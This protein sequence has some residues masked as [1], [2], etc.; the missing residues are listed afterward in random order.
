[1][2]EKFQRAVEDLYSRGLSDN[3]ISQILT[4]TGDYGD[5]IEAVRFSVS[6]YN[7]KKREET[8]T[9]PASADSLSGLDLNKASQDTASAS[10]GTGKPKRDT[11]PEV[12]VNV[13]RPTTMGT[14]DPS[15]ARVTLDPRGLDERLGRVV[16]GSARPEVKSAMREAEL[17]D[18]LKA[19]LAKRD[20]DQAQNLTSQFVTDDDKAMELALGVAKQDRG[21]MARGYNMRQYGYSEQAIEYAEEIN[22]LRAERK[23]NQELS[24]AADIREMAKQRGGESEV[25]LPSWATAT[26]GA[27]SSAA[28]ATN[29]AGMATMNTWLTETVEDIYRGVQTGYRGAKATPD[30]LTAFTK[31][32]DNLTNEQI[33]NI[34]A[35]LE[36]G[37]PSDEMLEFNARTLE[38]GNDFFAFFKALAAN[39]NPSGVVMEMIANSMAMLGNEASLKAGA[40]VLAP[41]A[42]R[43]TLQGGAAGASFGG[44]GAVPGAVVGTAKGILQGIP[45]AFSVASTTSATGMMFMQFVQEELDK[46]GKELNR[47]NVRAIMENDNLFNRFRTDALK[48]GATLGAI[49]L[50]TAKMASSVGANLIRRGRIGTGATAQAFG[51]GVGGATAENY[52]Q[53]AIGREAT[54]FELGAEFIAQVAQGAPGTFANIAKAALPK[55]LVEGTYKVNGETVDRDAVLRLVSMTPDAE[56]ESMGI[57]V[58][59][60][61][62]LQDLIDVKKRRNEIRKEMPADMPESQRER[63]VELELEKQMGD[64]KTE[65][66]KK[67]RAEIDEE[68]QSILNPD[69]KKDEET[70][71]EEPSKEETKEEAPAKEEGP[72]EVQ[73]KGEKYTVSKDENGETVVVKAATGRKAKKGSKNYNAAVEAA[74]GQETAD[75]QSEPEVDEFTKE[76]NDY[77]EKHRNS[78][79]VEPGKVVPKGDVSGR[80][81][82]LLN[83]L[84]RVFKTP[85]EIHKTR[86]S[87]AAASKTAYAAMKQGLEVRGF[88][89]DSDGVVHIFDDG[90]KQTRKTIVHEFLHSEN[91]KNRQ[92]ME[93]V[94]NSIVEAAK[95]NETLQEYIDNI[96]NTYE[97]IGFTPDEIMDEIVANFGSDAKSSQFENVAW[98]TIRQAINRMFEQLGLGDVYR[99]KSKN[100][101]VEYLDGVSRATRGLE[102]PGSKTGQ[103]TESQ[104]AAGDKLSVDRP[105]SRYAN[106]KTEYVKRMLNHAVSNKVLTNYVADKYAK[107]ANKFR[108]GYLKYNK[109]SYL[110]ALVGLDAKL[111]KFLKKRFK[112]EGRNYAPGARPDPY[113]GV[114]KLHIGEDIS[115]LARKRQ[116]GELKEMNV[117]IQGRVKC[118]I[119]GGCHKSVQ[120]QR[121]R[122]M[123]QVTAPVITHNMS[124]EQK[125]DLIGKHIAEDI[126]VSQDILP[127][128]FAR[129]ENLY[130]DFRTEFPNEVAAILGDDVV[131][132]HE[133]LLPVLGA[134]TSNGND[135]L[136]N[137]KDTI[138]AIESIA[139]TGAISNT[140][141]DGMTSRQAIRDGMQVLNILLKRPEF[142]GATMQETI[143]NI[144]AWMFQEQTVQEFL[145]ENDQAKDPLY[146]YSEYAK[147]AFPKDTV[148]PRSAMLF[149]PKIGVFMAALNGNENILVHDTWIERFRK[150]IAGEF[151]LGLTR[152]EIKAWKAK[153]KPIRGKGYRFDRDAITDLQ[154]YYAFAYGKKEAGMPLDDTEAM[155][156][157]MGKKLFGKFNE[158]VS[159]PN[160]RIM[161]E[162]VKNA[163]KILSEQ[164]VEL[165][166]AQI[167]QVLFFN[168]HELYSEAGMQNPNT[169]LYSESGKKYRNQ[170]ESVSDQEVREFIEEN[171]KEIRDKLAASKKNPFEGR[172]VV[173][174][175]HA[176]SKSGLYRP[177]TVSFQP[178][179]Y[180]D[181]MKWHNRMTGNGKVPFDEIYS[182]ELTDEFGTTTK[183]AEQPSRPFL[184]ENSDPKHMKSTVLNFRSLGSTQFLTGKAVEKFPTSVLVMKQRMG[185]KLSVDISAS[186]VGDIQGLMAYDAFSAKR[187]ASPT[188]DANRHFVPTDEKDSMDAEESPFFKHRDSA[189]FDSIE[190]AY[191]L[192]GATFNVNSESQARIVSFEGVEAMDNEVTGTRSETSRDFLSFDGVR[193]RYN[194][195]SSSAYTDAGGRPIKS[196]ETAVVVGDDVFVRG[197][198]E[199]GSMEDSDVDGEM[200]LLHIGKEAS[201][202]EGYR[203][204]LTRFVRY[205]DSQGIKFVNDEEAKDAYRSLSPQQR[206]QMD[207]SQTVDR[208]NRA[209]DML[210]ATEKVRGFIEGNIS[211]I[212][213]ST[214]RG[215]ILKNPE[216]Y[217]TPQ[218]LKTIKAD[219]EGMSTADLITNMRED[220]LASLRE[221]DD[222]YVGVL[223]GVELINRAI[224]NGDTAA[225]PGLYEELGKLGT[226]FGQGLRH[227]AE[228]KSSTPA[229]LYS[230]VKN[231]VES[232]GNMLTDQQEKELAAITSRVF[233][234][235]KA[236]AEMEEKIANELADDSALES[237]LQELKEAQKELDG[238]TVRTVERNYSELLVPIMQGNLI[239]LKSQGINVASNYAQ[240]LLGAG[241]DLVS[242]PIE[243]VLNL[244]G[245]DSDPR[246]LSILSYVYGARKY[247]SAT[248]ESVKDA[249]NGQ[250][251]DVTEW[252]QYRGFAPFRALQAAMSSDALPVDSQTGKPSVRQRL[253]LLLEG[254][255]AIPAETMFRLLSLGD[256]NVRKYTEEVF[257]DQLGRGYGLTGEALAKFRKNPPAAIKEKAEQRGRQMTFQDQ[258]AASMAAQGLTQGIINFLNRLGVPPA[259]SSF[260]VRSQVPFVKTP[261]N[262]LDE[263]AQYLSPVY[264]GI[265]ILSG[266][267]NNDARYASEATA[268]MIIGGSATYVA[269]MLIANGLASGSGMD[270]DEK[271]MRS[272]M[273][274]TLPPNSINVSGVKRWLNGEDSQYKPGDHVASYRSIGLLGQIIGATAAAQTPEQSQEIA[275][276]P[277]SSMKALRRLVGSNQFGIIANI[278]DQSFLQGLSGLTTVLTEVDPNRRDKAIDRWMESTWRAV[279]AVPLP[280]QL[281]QFHKAEREYLPAYSDFEVGEG[282]LINVLK[283]RLFIQT[284]IPPKRDWKGDPIKQTP[285]GSSPLFYNVFDITN[286]RQGTSDPVTVE[287]YRLAIA[288]EGV[289]PT[290]VGYPRY[291]ARRTI[292]LN[293]LLPT[294]GT[295]KQFGKAY[296]ASGKRYSFV[297]DFMRGQMKE[298]FDKVELGP[299]QISDLME[300]VGKARYADV[301]RVIR[302]ERYQLADTQTQIEVIDKYVSNNYNGVREFNRNGTFKDH[303]EMILDIV[304][305]AYDE[306]RPQED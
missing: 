159:K 94:Y 28:N 291:I 35:S 196:A 164:G 256:Y 154:R 178:T 194:P 1:M 284:D 288:N 93:S 171:N 118:Q 108:D 287:M 131:L 34:I 127:E 61:G 109:K 42:L 286:A 57:E 66:G 301:S 182:Y 84:S 112:E 238:F 150:R 252:R 59:N 186:R 167:G 248:K 4:L 41:S 9:E 202:P 181:Y 92:M 124:E 151:Q 135:T 169:S 218:K 177:I 192:N 62:S 279:T 250:D 67:R 303:T 91:A 283:D 18:Q 255:L 272:I 233:D 75:T 249:V 68:I 85:V 39:P 189:D 262:I 179:S 219:L 241:V 220:A 123:S 251:P 12:G 156:L 265:H 44:A 72:K 161:L 203:D 53:K 64:A 90:T 162:A 63:L 120:A 116:L 125:A 221:K 229:T 187:H 88:Y 22:K 175:F 52:A 188:E 193:V 155:A 145:E 282:R 101:L 27:L 121:Q 11:K 5:D 60:D 294:V 56:L 21:S 115:A 165:S 142:Q 134:I 45:Y 13:G 17:V 281:S 199:Y 128:S 173:G 191:E 214:V 38:E 141:M 263:L 79:R 253:K 264:A 204:G 247:V 195:F 26:V 174:L 82:R 110:D 190:G 30:V 36:S 244:L 83:V 269:S 298:G 143:E 176:E 237:V 201:D 100:D 104:S 231:L 271:R 8:A 50:V 114:D 278:M 96:R 306:Y 69:Q 113:T 99:I 172:K 7:K 16:P 149:G 111:D 147:T 292:K 105:H 81:A 126:I 275:K 160:R 2:N 170:L 260:L 300:L 37:G 10:L 243:K 295:R 19:E 158:N 71:A 20:P 236:Y 80:N 163:Q 276:D 157:Y 184:D 254:T 73:V 268:K 152:D 15:G 87:L 212:K 297:E 47:E 33:D 49:D 277:F 198:I 209:Y 51:E 216:N 185:E 95:Q 65:A 70:K 235:Q 40:G 200:D 86:E 137:V 144:N 245:M 211:K 148:V 129:G 222:D 267:K 205:A 14:T 168:E 32:N 25:N 78:R 197:K 226:F 261:S 230:F 54:A 290:L 215:T 46:Q 206:Q 31:G 133:G 23:R 122:A 280:N 208:A 296:A 258:R 207:T 180:Y 48:Y 166:P 270:D 273:Y 103:G 89:R 74:K 210:S 132:Q 102:R 6:E 138:D 302:D 98:S 240:I 3:A 136:T 234:A 130:S 29:P 304:Q 146:Q 139:K 242:Y 224:R 153:M 183:R 259:A 24:Q 119:T 43:G 77:G 246:K 76:F 55:P 227:F 225:I 140:I 107:Q 274:D 117:D 232:R 239:T 293:E 213:D 228:L 285:E 223:A 257:L 266:I 217:Y 289:P 97:Q 58:E 106:E 299:Q 305:K